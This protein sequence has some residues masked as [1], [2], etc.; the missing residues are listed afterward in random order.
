MAGGVSMMKHSIGFVRAH[1]FNWPFIYR[2]I[3]SMKILSE[4][5]EIRLSNQIRSRGVET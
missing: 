5:S 4:D 1:A 3:V 2:I